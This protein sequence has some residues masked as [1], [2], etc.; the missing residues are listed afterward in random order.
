MK[1]LLLLFL[2][3]TMLSCSSDD[4]PATTNPPASN[5]VLVSEATA[6]LAE[7]NQLG[8]KFNFSALVKNNKSTSVTGKVMFT[9]PNG[10]A[11]NY[12]YIEDITLSPGETKTVSSVTGGYYQTET[13]TISSATFVE[14]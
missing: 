14:E 1:K 12:A 10:A 13:I 4:A 11:T 5:T 7:T 9:V 2:G 3:A 6:T 8:Y